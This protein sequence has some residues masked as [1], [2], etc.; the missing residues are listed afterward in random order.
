MKNPVLLQWDLQTANFV[1]ES[2]RSTR[3][4]AQ[5]GHVAVQKLQ[6]LLPKLILVI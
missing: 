4:S 1:F 6:L 3:P 2:S 5:L